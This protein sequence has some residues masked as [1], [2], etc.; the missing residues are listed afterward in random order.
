M[1]KTGRD[2]SQIVKEEHLIQITDESELEQIIEKVLIEN[3]GPISDFKKGKKQ[4]LGFL[5]GQV[6]RITQGKANPKL[7]NQI[8]IEKLQISD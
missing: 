2:A 3:P 7:V 1:Y 5:V 6:M 4:A 8:L